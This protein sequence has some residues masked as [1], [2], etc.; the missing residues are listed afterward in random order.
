MKVVAIQGSPHKGNTH[1]RVE[2]FGRELV[3]LGDVEFEHIALKDADVRPC[4]GCFSCFVNG[5]DSCPLDDDLRGIAAKLIEADA[6]V[7][8]SPVYAMH[9][10]YLFKRFVDRSAYTFHRPRYFGKYAVGLAVTGGIGLK[11]ALEYIR[12]CAGT[13]G[14]EYVADLRY[15]DPP[16][17]TKMGR[18][19]DEPDRTARVARELHSLMAT[20]PP[21]RVSKNDHL[22][23]HA[24][25]AVYERMEERSPADYGYWKERGWLDPRTRYFTEHARVGYLKS[26]YPRFVA[27]MIRR[28]LRKRD[29]AD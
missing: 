23:F 11:E 6:A 18:F 13:W 9:V 2:A 28:A 22:M 1:D 5:E 14:F 17:G 12:M 25:R 4:L 26:V 15:V 8:A 20:K 3:S 21:R 16:R 7:F 24:M 29:G 27:W 19:T 10:S